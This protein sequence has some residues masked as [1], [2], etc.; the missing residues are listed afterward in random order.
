MDFNSKINK[1]NQNKSSCFAM[2]LQEIADSM[3]L[4][5]ERVRQIEAKAIHKLRKKH[6]RLG[7]NSYDKITN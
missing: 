6:G 5:R 1:W 4:T 7:I 2:T 3:N